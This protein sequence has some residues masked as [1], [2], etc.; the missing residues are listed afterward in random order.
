MKFQATHVIRY[1]G[2]SIEVREVDGALYTAEEWD[3]S[4]ISDWELVDGEVLFQGQRTYATLEK[5]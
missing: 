5:V 2:R 1:Q 3:T 4:D